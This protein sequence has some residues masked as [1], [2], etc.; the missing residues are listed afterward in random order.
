MGGVITEISE[1]T[2]EVEEEEVMSAEK[3]Q[4]L[5]QSSLTA[6]ANEFKK[7]TD[8]MFDPASFSSEGPCLCPDV[9]C[10]QQNQYYGYSRSDTFLLQCKYKIACG[11]V[12]PIL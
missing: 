11:D 4:E 12:I 7:V 8:A 1:A 6:Q 2:A 5:I 10:Q 9:V 3:I